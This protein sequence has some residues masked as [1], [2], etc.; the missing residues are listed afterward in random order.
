MCKEF[1]QNCYIKLLVSY[2]WKCVYNINF[3]EAFHHLQFWYIRVLVEWVF[4]KL[5]LRVFVF[6]GLQNLVQLIFRVDIY[7]SLAQ[8]ESKSG[9][10]ISCNYWSPYTLPI[11][12]QCIGSLYKF[13]LRSALAVGYI[14]RL[15]VKHIMKKTNSVLAST[16][17]NLVVASVKVQFNL[18]SNCL[19]ILLTSRKNL[20]R[21]V[22]TYYWP[23]ITI[24]R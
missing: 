11:T 3:F 4:A 2:R 13:F 15:S 16:T 7:V 24:Y 8:L 14:C 20:Q 23:K 5:F 12:I 6:L 19:K 9:K 21:N 17:L 22:M 10:L 18:R 1:I